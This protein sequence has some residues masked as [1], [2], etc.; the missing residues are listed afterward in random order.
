MIAGPVEATALGNGLIQ[1]RA[2]GAV[3]DLDA[4]RQLIIDTQPLRRYQPNG[5]ESAWAAAERRLPT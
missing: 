3:G 2:L 1:A 4:L 5:T